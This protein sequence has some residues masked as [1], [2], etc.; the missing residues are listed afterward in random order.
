[1]ILN[2]YSPLS[3]A[4]EGYGEGEENVIGKWEN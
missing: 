1:M 4:G 2:P 3:F